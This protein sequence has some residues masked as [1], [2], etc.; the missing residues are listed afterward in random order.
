MPSD[1]ELYKAYQLDGPEDAKDLYGKWADTYDSSFGEGL[2]YVAPREI[3]AIY[4]ELS[5]GDAPLLDIGAG[6]GL[7][8][9]NLG[10]VVVDALDITPQ[11]LDVAADK[12][13][14]RDLIIADLLQRL[15]IDDA[16]YGGVISSGTFT[17]GHV[18]PACLPELLRVTRTGALFVC[19]CI[20]AV[21]DDMGFGSILAILNAQG[22]IGELNFRDIPIYE[23]RDHPHDRGIVMIFR[24]L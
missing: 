19:G 5:D 11:M 7:I 6:T 10:D 3:A 1:D 23:G 16:S 22:A 24:K 18:G 14:Y 2:G 4:R 12:G 8:A 17:H 13:L 20:P 21:F 9:E 15:P